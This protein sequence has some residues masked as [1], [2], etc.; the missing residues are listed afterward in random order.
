M[1]TFGPS[2]RGSHARRARWSSLVAIIALVAAGGTAYATIPGPDG[3]IHGCYAKSGGALR[4]VD[5]GVTNCK[6]GETSLNWDQHGS[7]GST[8]TTGPQGETGPQG[9]TGPSGGFSGWE[10]VSGSHE[11]LAPFPSDPFALSASADCPAGKKILGAFG[12]VQLFN[13]QGFLQSGEVANIQTDP[14]GKV[15][16]AEAE[17][18]EISGVTRLVITSQ[19]TCAVP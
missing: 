8:G 11:Y 9:P 19:A 13:D 15:A 17:P 4:V 6:S 3:V 1:N 18:P 10:L 5:A 14:D 16:D 12:L 2:P 7:Q